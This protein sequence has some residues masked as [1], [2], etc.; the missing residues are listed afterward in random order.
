MRWEKQ[1]LIFR[2]DNNFPWMMHH[3]CV[4]IADPSRSFVDA[5]D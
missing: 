1:G 3:A 4:P 5:N 2:T